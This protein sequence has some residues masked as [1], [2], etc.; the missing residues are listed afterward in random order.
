LQPGVDEQDSVLLP[1]YSSFIP[2]GTRD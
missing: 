1:S 2:L